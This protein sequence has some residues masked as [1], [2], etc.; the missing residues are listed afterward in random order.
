MKKINDYPEY[1][2]TSKSGNRDSILEFKKESVE[3]LHVI[4]FCT[5]YGDV[6]YR[7][8]FPKYRLDIF[9]KRLNDSHYYTTKEKVLNS[10]NNESIL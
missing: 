1:I 3:E 2:Y 8:A 10:I 7:I 4:Y 5:N 6:D 9:M